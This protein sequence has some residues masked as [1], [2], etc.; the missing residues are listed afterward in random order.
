MIIKYNIFENMSDDEIDDLL[1]KMSKYGKDSLNNVEL[2][3]LKNYD[4]PNYNEQEEIINNIIKIVGK[5]DGYISLS[6]LETET[7]II[8]DDIKNQIG[9]MV[10]IIETLTEEDVMISVYHNYDDLLEEYQLSYD[11]LDLDTLHQI[12]NTLIKAEKHEIIN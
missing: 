1:D 10:H 4:N 7:D 3:K 9:R 11:Q 8:H 6:E 12:Y 2:S 5:N